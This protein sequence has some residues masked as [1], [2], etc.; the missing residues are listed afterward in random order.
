MKI[1]KNEFT[2]TKTKSMW[3]IASSVRKISVEYKFPKKSYPTVDDAVKA[4]T[5]MTE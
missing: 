3:V 2:V 1:G 5:E 4:L